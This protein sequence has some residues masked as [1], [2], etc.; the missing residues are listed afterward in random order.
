MH[1]ISAGGPRDVETIV[2]EQA[3][4]RAVCNGSRARRQ[5]VK[6]SRGE[7]FLTYLN[8]G[9]SGG[10]GC[11]DEPQDVYEAGIFR[12][13][14]RRRLAGRYRVSDRECNLERHVLQA[15]WAGQFGVEARLPFV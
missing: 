15:C 4:R 1:T 3:R 8:E 10:Y 14:L 5:F 2:D 13:C 9:E 7:C 12:S 11:F 6:N